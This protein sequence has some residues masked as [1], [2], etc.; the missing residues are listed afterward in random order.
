MLW[1]QQSVMMTTSNLYSREGEYK[2]INNT[3]VMDKHESINFPNVKV[4]LTFIEEGQKH[5]SLFYHCGFS[6]KPFFCRAQAQF[7]IP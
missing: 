4:F 3:E 7:G 5:I 6:T 1:Q 2:T